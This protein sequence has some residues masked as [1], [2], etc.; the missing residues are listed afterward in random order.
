M[1]LYKAKNW[2]ILILV[3]K[4][5]FWLG[6]IRVHELAKELNCDSKTIIQQLGKM[7]CVV[8]NHMSIIEENIVAKVRE[9]FAA[10]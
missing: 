8:K 7:G 6:K 4:G 9:K 5:V 1:I 3:L 2:L 10:G